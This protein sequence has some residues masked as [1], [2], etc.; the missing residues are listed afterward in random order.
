[1]GI[2]SCMY[3]MF[4]TH[5]ILLRIMYMSHI[6]LY[7]DKHD[8]LQFGINIYHQHIRYITNISRPTY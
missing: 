5:D 2:Y 3:I 6:G 7:Y 4:I 1:M 8:M